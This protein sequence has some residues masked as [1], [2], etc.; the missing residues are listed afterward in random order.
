MFAGIDPTK[1]YDEE[2]LAYAKALRDSTGKAESKTPAAGIANMLAQVINGYTIK[3]QGDLK[4]S[5]DADFYKQIFGAKPAEGQSALDAYATAAA[6]AAQSN[7]RFA[8]QAAQMQMNA[9]LKG[10]ELRQKEMESKL[11][12]QLLGGNGATN[13]QSG[14]MGANAMTALALTNPAAATA[15][16]NTDPVFIKNREKAKEAGKNEAEKQGTFSKAQASLKGFEQQAS[17]VDS[18]IDKAIGT[19]SPSSTGFGAY[20]SGVPNSDAGKLKNYLDTIKANVGFDKLQS[21]RENSPTGG[22]LGQVSDM[23][24]KLLQAVNGALDPK[25]SDQLAENLKS[26]KA[27]YPQVLKE[28]RSA[29]KQDYSGVPGYSQWWKDGSQEGAGPDISQAK[30]GGDGKMYIP[31]P[32]RPGKYLLVGD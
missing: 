22:A 17:L 3:K 10:P 1:Q 20:L 24:N 11:M 4:S 18:T 19:I 6:S 15:L 13:D 25:Q 30:Q 16:A 12:A 23:E 9:A 8:E 31:D 21:M 2:T 14:G 5:E 29:F 7:P 32:N 28:K 27:L 26:I